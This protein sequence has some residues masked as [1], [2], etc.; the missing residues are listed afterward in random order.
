MYRQHI[1]YICI[2]AALYQ[3]EVADILNSSM[4]GGKYVIYEGMS[5]LSLYLFVVT[6]FPLINIGTSLTE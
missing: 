1:C 3:N 4:I 2:E 5:R 6:A